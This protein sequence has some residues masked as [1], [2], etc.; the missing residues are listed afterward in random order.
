MTSEDRR[1]ARYLCRKEKREARKREVLEKHSFYHVYSRNALIKAAE[2]ATRNVWYKASVK[3]YMQRRIENISILSNNLIRRKDI[4]RRFICFSLFE[5][6]K[7]RKIMSVHFA[8]WVPQ[9][10]LNQNALLPVLSR[11]LIYDNGAS[12]KGKGTL[13][14]LNGLTVHLRRHYRLHG[15]VGYILLIDFSD[16][17]NNIDHN[18]AKR[19]IRDNFDDDG[20]VW[21]QNYLLMHMPSIIKRSYIYQ[22]NR[23][24]KVL[25]LAA[26]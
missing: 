2:D 9:K 1:T 17:F 18:I 16:Y 21:L 13:F 11:T 24:G 7:Y 4:R 14:S 12:Q 6:G 8:E 15:N 26:K 19:I 23:L 10:S 25:G 5:R 20:I 3:R 22:R